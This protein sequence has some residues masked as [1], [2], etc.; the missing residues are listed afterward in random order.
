M[1][2]DWMQERYEDR[3]LPKLKRRYQQGKPYPHFALPSFLHH[4]KARKLFKHLIQQTFHPKVSD[5]Y[6]FS[7]TNDLTQHEAFQDFH[8]FLEALLPWMSEITGHELTKVDLHGTLYEDTDVLLPHDDTL[9]ERKVA[10]LLYLS[11]MDDE[12]GGKLALFKDNQVKTRI[13]PIFNLFC[14][15]DVT[16]DSVHAVEEILQDKKRYALGGWFS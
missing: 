1:I 5:L 8:Q 10:Y 14:C 11:T 15:F 3:P 16:K 4:L 9:D 2:K 6:A 12:D 13:Q 7:Q